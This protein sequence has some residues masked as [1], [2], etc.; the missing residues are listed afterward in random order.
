MLGDEDG[1]HA[2]FAEL[3]DDPILAVDDGVCR[4]LGHGP[5]RRSYHAR[6]RVRLIRVRD[7]ERGDRVVPEERLGGGA[8]ERAGAGHMVLALELGERTT[9]TAGEVAVDGAAH[10]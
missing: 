8:V 10:V 6:W 7:E 4:E 3:T 5:P 2:A 9:R 1:A